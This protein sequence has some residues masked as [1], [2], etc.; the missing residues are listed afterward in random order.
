[1]SRKDLRELCSAPNESRTAQSGE[2]FRYWVALG[3]NSIDAGEQLAEA[4]KRLASL[5]TTSVAVSSYY[6]TQPIGPAEHP[7]LNAAAQFCSRRTPHDLLA[8]LQRL[9]GDAG[10]T[11]HGTRWG[12]RPLDLDI[13]AAARDERPVECDDATLRLPHP[14]AHLRRFVL[15]P[16]V[17]LPSPQ[18][19]LRSG[20]A[21]ECRVRLLKRPLRVAGVAAEHLP[22]VAIATGVHATAAIDLRPGGRDAGLLRFVPLPPEA[23]RAAIVA[24]ACDEP[25]RVAQTG[26][27]QFAPR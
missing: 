11:Q 14:L 13:V 21:D 7:F 16:L 23:A 27:V 5:S 20:K 17:E 6:R 3:S 25:V 9:E 1:M 19:R 24:M 12:D 26:P 10:R 8:A 22:A 2:L 18:P 15:D 4:G